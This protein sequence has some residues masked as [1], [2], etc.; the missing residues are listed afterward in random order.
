M[1]WVDVPP[2]EFLHRALQIRPDIIGLSGLLTSSYDSMRETIACR[3]SAILRSADPD[4]HCQQLN[5][6]VCQYVSADAW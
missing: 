3:I 1:I 2:P 6:Q 5:E 4:R